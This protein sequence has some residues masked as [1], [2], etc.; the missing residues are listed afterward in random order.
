MSA[1]EALGTIWAGVDRL[2]E[3]ADEPALVLHRL[4]PLAAA[5]LRR[6]G[7]EVP[8]E[9][10]EVERLGAA[11]ALAATAHLTRARA[12]VD[13]PLLLIKGPELA[14][15][16]PEPSLRISRDLDLVAPDPAAVQAALL[17]A[18]FVESGDPDLYGRAPHL[19]PVAWPRLPV[20][21]EVHA[22][23]NW[24]R[25]AAAP[26][27]AELL[28]G[29]R[30]SAAGV[31]GVIA[32]APEKH[33]LVVA[34]HAWTHGPLERLRDLLDVALLATRADLAETERLARAWGIL[35]LW[36][37]TEAVARSL[38]LGEPAPRALRGWAKNLAEA[39]ERTVLEQHTARW[40]CWWDAFPPGVAAR[41][42][43]D[44][45]REDVTPDPGETWS[46]KARRSRRA[47]RN[48]FVRRSE[49]DRAAPK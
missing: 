10:L 24:P 14:A 3:R 8:P 48:A 23:P 25:W 34:V 27:A 35:R 36:R 1:N 7:E 31:E 17:A 15:L 38:Y 2:V 33:L 6:L 22:R 47:V 13:E 19:V 40:R 18:G 20:E 30:P 9:L 4:E 16:Y 5:R 44:E 45:L 11:F 46:A 29:A 39:R 12:S 49:H 37:T 43:L 28:E 41:A 42:T 26:T 32:P 21:V